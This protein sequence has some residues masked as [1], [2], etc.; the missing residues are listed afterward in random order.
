ML[1]EE[2]RRPDDRARSAGT[3]LY[4]VDV[5]DPANP[6]LDSRTSWSG[7]QLS[8]RQYDD[9]VRLVTST[10]LPAAAVR[11]AR[12]AGISARRGRA[13][14]PRDRPELD[15]AGL[16][17]RP[18][19]QR[20]LPPADLVRVGDGVRGHVPSR[21]GR[22]RNAGGGHRG[23][24][25]GLL[26]GRPALRDRDRL[27]WPGRDG[28]ADDQSDDR[29]RSGEFRPMPPTRTHIHAFALEGT[30]PVTWPRATS[31]AP[32]R[33]AGHSTRGTGTCASPSPGP[34]ETGRHARTGSSYSTSG[35]IGWRPSASCV[36][37]ASTSRSS[38]CAGSTTWPWS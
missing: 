33:T 9:T 6:R 18:R 11:A 25:R 26:L 23:R 30:R 1:E 15:R 29:S 38:R 31:A 20:G 32:S 35:V 34:I 22:R 12:P 37:S 13:A 19:L 4:D 28:P 16:G 21:R 36:A 27:G 10:G 7:R 24:Q 14:Q 8:L 2:A 17:T 3:E 5:S